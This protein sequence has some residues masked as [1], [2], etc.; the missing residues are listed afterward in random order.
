MFKKAERHKGY[1]KNAITGPSGSGKTYSALLLASGM[2]QKIALIDTENGSASLYSD[3]FQFDTMTIDPP[4]TIEKF[5]FAVQA[6]Q[7]AKY[8]VLV[9]DS[10]SHAWA[11]DGGLLAKKESLDARGGNSYTN[12]SSITKEQELF[13]STILNAKVHIICTMRSKQDYILETDHKGKSSPKKV[14]L[15][16]IQRDGMEYEFTTVFDLAMNHEAQISKDRTG[17]F[18]GKIFKITENTGKS[19]LA[20][21]AGATELPKVESKKEEHP[22]EVTA[23]APQSDNGA[24][25]SADYDETMAY[26]DSPPAAPR[27]QGVNFEKA[28]IEYGEQRCLDIILETAELPE[29]IVRMLKD[30][31]AILDTGVKLTPRQ[32]DSFSKSWWMNMVRPYENR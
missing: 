29:G 26:F 31:R 20:W 22:I 15:A 14:G 21:L 2:G 19:I 1:L 3:R 28:L 18:D 10:I 13:K 27:G 12:W 11:G 32:R 24:G 8:D 6:A 7:D 23:I 25:L 4:Y 17:L 9:I 5:K 30:F 16:P